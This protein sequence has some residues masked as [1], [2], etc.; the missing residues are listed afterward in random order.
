MFVELDNNS[1]AFHNLNYNYSCIFLQVELH[2]TWEIW[3]FL[4]DKIISESEEAT[5]TK[6]GVHACDINPYLHEF[7]EPILI[8]EIFD[9]H[10]L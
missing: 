3:P 4:K 10:G 8:N 2:N 1:V 6:I 7:F 5:P 9:D